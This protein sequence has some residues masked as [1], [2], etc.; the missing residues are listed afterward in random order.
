MQ[1]VAVTVGRVPIPFSGYSGA[2]YTWGRGQRPFPFGQSLDVAASSATL[3]LLRQCLDR[4]ESALADMAA[5]CGS[6]SAQPPVLVVSP[7]Y[8]SCDTADGMT[9]IDTDLQD[10]LAHPDQMTEA[11]AIA[12]VKAIQP[13]ADCADL[14]A[15]ATDSPAAQSIVKSGMPAPAPKP[16]PTPG[17]PTPGKGGPGNT[18][19]LSIPWFVWA[20]AGV[21]ILVALLASRR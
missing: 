20:G 9:A 4:F 7:S 11:R 19:G 2:K 16:T 8:Q 12:F 6:D 18:P 5:Q 1:G 15:A 21:V 13:Y 10:Q 14:V 17:T 3:A